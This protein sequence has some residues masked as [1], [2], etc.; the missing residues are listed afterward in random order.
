M[1]GCLCG[2][3]DLFLYQGGRSVPSE[4][5]IAMDDQLPDPQYGSDDFARFL[6]D[7]NDNSVLFTQD[8]LMCSSFAHADIMATGNMNCRSTRYG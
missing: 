4:L 6:F 5:I 3:S 2:T 1:D 8:H 7:A